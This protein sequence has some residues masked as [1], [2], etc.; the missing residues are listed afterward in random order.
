MFNKL[1]NV[2]ILLPAQTVVRFIKSLKVLK[3]LVSLPKDPNTL[4]KTL[5]IA[6]LL[7]IIASD[8]L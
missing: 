2:A 6:S 7:V 8:S 1:I 5:K 3:Q 4:I